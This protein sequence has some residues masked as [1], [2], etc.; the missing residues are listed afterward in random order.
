M[1]ESGGQCS[2][3]ETMSFIGDVGLR[4]R[5]LQQKVYGILQL[6]SCVQKG[7]RG[8]VGVM[9]SEQGWWMSISDV[10]SRMAALRE[11]KDLLKKLETGTYEAETE[12]G[13]WKVEA[14]ADGGKTEA[15][16]E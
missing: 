4:P 7:R 15:E 13:R 6:S 1:E 8:R 14:E 2:F 3:V 9:F 16:A 5:I 12:G 11:K 10:K